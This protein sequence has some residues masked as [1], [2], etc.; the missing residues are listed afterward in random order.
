[1]D[2]DEV[3]LP[4]TV[5]LPVLALRD[6][7]VF[8]H[9]T[10]PLTVGR[11]ASRDLLRRLPEDKRVLLVL[12][13]D[14]HQDEP[15]PVD[16]Y[17]VGV[18]VEVVKSAEIDGEGHMVALARGVGRARIV[19]ELQRTPHL[20]VRAEVLG[21]IVPS[22][23]DAEFLAMAQNV[24]DL[25]A[26]VVAMS[27]V[28]SNDLIPLVESM[29][30]VATLTDVVASV[31]PSLGAPVRQEL[32]ETVDVRRRLRRLTEELVKERE[33]MVLRS[34]L[35]AEVHER[36][37]EDQRRFFLREQL[38]AIKQE[39][40]ESE[41]GQRDIE[42]IREKIEAA[43]MPAKVKEEALRELQRLSQLPAAAPDHALTRTY[44]DWLTSLPWTRVSTALV[45]VERAQ[46]ILDEDHHDLEKVK[47][48]IVE[49]LAVM[50]LTNS[51][52]GPILCFVGPPGVGK[53]SLGKSIAR[54]LDRP[55]VRV[56]LGG[57]HDEAEIRGHRRTYIGA[58]PGQI[59]QGIRRA[60][61][62]DPV[63]MLDEIDKL[64]KD[65]RGDPAAA[66]LEVLDPEQNVAFQDHYLDAP[67]DLSRVL[68]ITTANLLDPVPP[69]LL[70]RMEVLELAGY[71]ESEKIEIARRYLIPKQVRAHG[72]SSER[73]IHFREEALREIIRGYTR[74]A[75][76]RN[77]EREIGA[78][79]RK[80]ARQVAGGRESLLDVT[81]AA[82]RARLGVPRFELETEIADRVARPGV[83]VAL[84]WT[85]QGGDILFV[86]AS[87]MPR[88]R[89]EVIITGQ[90]GDVMQESVKAAFTWV[91]ST[92]ERYGLH[93]DD[94]RRYD[95]HV[96]VPSGAVP[97]DG[98]SA[99][100]VMVTALMSLF[101]DLP[102]RPWV[103]QSGEITLSGQVL[104]VGGIKEKVLAARRSGVR[105]VVLSRKN[106]PLVEQDLPREL[107][108]DLIFH[109]VSQIEEA[110]EYALGLPAIDRQAQ[111]DSGGLRQHQP[112]VPLSA[113]RP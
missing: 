32:V 25:C 78:V 24:R 45:D 76:V 64:G 72:L 77:L 110:L 75:G 22:P 70:D 43:G 86:E 104:P 31:L 106:R 112:E 107:R 69:A 37:G 102:V 57:M 6:T 19:Q 74:E 42:E 18:V 109:Y 7:V 8:P 84:A 5:E 14:P 81:P 16:L 79:C 93:G 85:P 9:A 12:Q 46:Q 87:R 105:E 39:L 44:L 60:G 4:S 67:F 63:F 29:E 61:A 99:G 11:P 15:G 17:S 13:R 89:G 56:S 10:A 55:F 52:R 82:V 95:V 65:F 20:R 88:D 73:H 30:D 35:Q 41:D 49:Y 47:E 51:L 80:H 111:A 38:K 50:S 23:P 2:S 53:T 58:L 92:G 68:F 33:N 91:R 101:L 62:A 3:S 100:V 21:D 1:M 113:R 96:H 71:T 34:R 108:E 59:I 48:R 36:L 40:G 26:Q 83:A 103:A 98:P 97:K 54:A 28:L 66:L 27:P 94:F 90:L